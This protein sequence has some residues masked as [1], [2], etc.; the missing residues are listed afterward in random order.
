MWQVVEGLL[1][2]TCTP[3]QLS[4]ET[5]KSKPVALVHA[6]LPHRRLVDGPNIQLYYCHEGVGQ[7]HPVPSNLCEGH[8]PEDNMHN[9]LNSNSCFPFIY[10]K[11][12]D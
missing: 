3:V 2:D 5:T 11:G 9:Y 6:S 1:W 10:T 4:N 12:K 8:A 7:E